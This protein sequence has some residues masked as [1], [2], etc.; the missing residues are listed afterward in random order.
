MS[1]KSLKTHRNVDSVL[2]K[3]EILEANEKVELNAIKLCGENK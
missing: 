3:C 1:K 2:V